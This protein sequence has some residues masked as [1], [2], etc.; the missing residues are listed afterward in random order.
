MLRVA[1]IAVL[2]TL[3]AET[4]AGASFNCARASTAVEKM[5]CADPSLSR[6]DERLAAQYAAAMEHADSGLLRSGQRAWLRETRPACDDAACL[7]LAYRQRIEELAAP[8]DEAA[9]STIASLDSRFRSLAIPEPQIDEATEKEVETALGG[10]EFESPDPGTTFLWHVDFDSDGIED[11]FG[12]DYGNGTAHVGSGHFLSGVAGSARQSFDA[13]YDRGAMDLSL[14]AFERRYYVVSSTM[15]DL[16]RL[17]RVGADGTFRA[18]CQF[19]A[20]MPEQTLV[21]G[22]GTPV[23]EAVARGGALT[24]SFNETHAISLPLP[25]DPFYEK[26]YPRD[27]VARVD[28]DNDGRTDSV[29]H[30]MHLDSAGRG[31]GAQLLAVVDES[32]TSFLPTDLNKLLFSFPGGQCGPM[33]ELLVFDGA[34]FV[35]SQPPGAREVFRISGVDADRI[36]DFRIATG[37]TFRMSTAAPASR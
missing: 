37:H 28:I 19:E 4:V 30:V 1:P 8:I 7:R 34:A 12:I 35:E 26:K 5:I 22:T 33:L 20:K 10:R 29:I 11:R 17:W 13:Y 16:D 2:L 21:A 9:C 32:R 3:F 24:A 18:V 14:V 36:C 31:C 23:C 27:G 6:L 25:G 15:R